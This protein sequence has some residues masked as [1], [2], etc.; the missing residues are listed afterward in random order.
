[1][2]GSMKRSRRVSLNRRK[3]IHGGSPSAEASVKASRIAANAGWLLYP[4]AVCSAAVAS[5]PA[6]TSCATRSSQASADS[7]NCSRALFASVLRMESGSHHPSS[8]PP[9][10]NATVSIGGTEMLSATEAITEMRITTMP[11]PTRPPSF[12]SA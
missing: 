3:P 4:L 2:N 7:L 1:M 6:V 11:P 10:A 8:E 5:D 9:A 12:A